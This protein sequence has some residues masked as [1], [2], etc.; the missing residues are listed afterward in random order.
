MKQVLL[1]ALAEGTL[2]VPVLA[3]YSL[4]TVNEAYE[5]FS[6]GS[7]LGKIILEV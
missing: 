3:R 7:K 6:A 4:D 2:S 1:P 5:R